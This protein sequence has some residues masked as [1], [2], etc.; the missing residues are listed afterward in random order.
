MVRRYTDDDVDPERLLLH[1]LGNSNWLIQR[2]DKEIHSE[3]L[4][5]GDP[6]TGPSR[7]F[8][9]ALR[10]RETRAEELS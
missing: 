10:T 2:P 6:E 7:A 3:D 9:L 5:C 8:P 1:D 4:S